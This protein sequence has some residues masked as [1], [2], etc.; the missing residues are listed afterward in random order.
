M[1]LRLTTG[2]SALGLYGWRVENPKLSYAYFYDVSNWLT[3][4]MISA[5]GISGYLRNFANLILIDQADG[6]LFGVAF[7][8]L[9]SFLFWPF[10]AMFRK[11]F[12]Y[13]TKPKD[14]QQQKPSKSESETETETETGFTG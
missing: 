10:K 6:F 3:G 1:W 11:S 9:I 7:M 5:E 2:L 13:F 14:Q 4:W 12:A 8:A